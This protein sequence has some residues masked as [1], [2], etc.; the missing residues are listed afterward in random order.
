MSEQLTRYHNKKIIEHLAHQYVLG[1]LTTRVC[2][3][4]EKLIITNPE[5]ALKICYWQNHFSSFDKQT[6]ELQPKIQT[7]QNIQQ[8]CDPQIT[9]SSKAHEEKNNKRFNFY[10]TV[11]VFF[12]MSIAV[13]SCFLFF[14]Q[15]DISKL[16][17]VAVLTDKNQQPQLVLRNLV[18]S[19]TITINI[20][21]IPQLSSEQDLELWAISNNAQKVRS[22]GIIPRKKNM[23]D[24]ELTN[25]QWLLIKE[26]NALMITV[27]NLGGSANGIPNTPILS[28]GVAA[29]LTK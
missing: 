24:K 28:R 17:Y 7:W 9:H 4:I 12:A 20:I 23:F 27:E 29:Q 13:L 5:F 1:L 14:D 2:A 6:V 10:P 19:K 11:S 8:V 16:N 18:K 26:S 3:R 25:S 21:N 22:L 15:N